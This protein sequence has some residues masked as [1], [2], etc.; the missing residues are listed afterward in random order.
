MRLPTSAKLKAL[1]VYANEGDT[2][3]SRK[4]TIVAPEGDARYPSGRYGWG[5]GSPYWS[6]TVAGR[7]KH[8]V[9][10]L[11]SG[12]ASTFHDSFRTCVSCVR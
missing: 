10:D 6:H 11:G 5:G 2:A 8:E 4:H 12:R 9:I 3:I 7:G 1:V